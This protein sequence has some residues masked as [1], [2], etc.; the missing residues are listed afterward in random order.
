MTSSSATYL[1]I[2][3]GTTALKCII[4]DHKQRVAGLAEVALAISRPRHGWAEQ[5][6]QD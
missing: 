2:D 6:P 4:T 3:L 1:G 5:T